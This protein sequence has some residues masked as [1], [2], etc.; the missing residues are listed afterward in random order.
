MEEMEKHIQ[1]G[2]AIKKK[3]SA[4][5]W[6][7]RPPERSSLTGHRMTITRVLFHPVYRYVAQDLWT[8]QDLPSLGVRDAVCHAE[9]QGAKLQRA[10]PKAVILLCN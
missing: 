8:G 1:S 5:D 2:G 3:S 9:D 10:F 4:A 7:P 6:I